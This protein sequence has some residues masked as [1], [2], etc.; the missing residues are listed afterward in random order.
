MRFFKKIYINQYIMHIKAVWKE[1]VRKIAPKASLC[2]FCTVFAKP[3]VEI[4]ATIGKKNQNN[5]GDS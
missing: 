1:M 4:T 5:R 2:K 3:N